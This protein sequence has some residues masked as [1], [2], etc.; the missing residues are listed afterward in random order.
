MTPQ[1]YVE[2]L[3][4]LFAAQRYQ[5]LL[6]FASAEQDHVVPPLS[7]KELLG[8]QDLAHVAA[9]TLQMNAEVRPAGEPRSTA[10]RP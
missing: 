1:E 5:E 10:A 6:D 7:L 4:G 9:T 3:E 8:I 2:H